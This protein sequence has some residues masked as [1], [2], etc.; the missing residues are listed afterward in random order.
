MK[1]D[2]KILLGIVVIIISVVVLVNISN[3]PIRIWDEAIY[4][5]NSLEMSQGDDWFILKN[6][7]EPN[8][9]NTKPPLMIW[10]Q[11]ICI[12]LFGPS[13][14]CKTS[15]FYCCGSFIDLDLPFLCIGLRKS[16]NWIF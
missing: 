11:A 10:S 8:L 15:F 9:Y 13:G 4:A 1:P 14:F 7:G 2:R 5:N 16:S 3:P 12:K 6:N